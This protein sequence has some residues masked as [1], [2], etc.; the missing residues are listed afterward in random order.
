MCILHMDSILGFEWD[1]GNVR[2]VE[3]RSFSVAD[4]ERAFLNGRGTYF[5]DL[6]HSETEDRH[7]LIE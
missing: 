4:L 2:K 6:R 5:P 3:A 7:W 1:D